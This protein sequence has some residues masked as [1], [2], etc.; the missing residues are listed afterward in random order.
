MARHL[1]HDSPQSAGGGEDSRTW[2]AKLTLTDF[3]NYE[4]HA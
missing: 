2:I 3:R 4:R 1:T